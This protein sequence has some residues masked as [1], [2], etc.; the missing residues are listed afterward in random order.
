MSR[1]PTLRSRQ[2]E[3]S[4]EL[5][6]P[7]DANGD[8]PRLR[9]RESGATEPPRRPSQLRRLREPLPLIGI[10]LVLVAFVGYLAVYSSTT[11]RTP[12]LV[13]TRALPAGSALRASDLR[14]AELAGDGSIIGGLES[15][16]A[17]GQ[18]VGQRLATGLPSGTPL[19]RSAL[20]DRAPAT[21]AMTLAVPAMHALGGRLQ[22]GDRVTVLATFGAGS[23]HAHTRP[24]ARGL[25]VLAVGRSPAS[26]DET[27]ATVPVTLALP[28][29]SIA[30]D[31]AL[32]GNDGKLDL[33]REGDR[34]TTS[35]IPQASEESGR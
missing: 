1:W 10:A 13:T 17:L 32:A 12:V 29:P 35:P 23:A 9:P 19:P 4:A 3:E 14:A 15:E 26:A 31:L 27:T 16:A 34:A 22:S 2:G 20:A 7:P 6:H 8:A 33:L 21:S 30:S 28:D 18:V 5:R 25:Q 24:I 11:H